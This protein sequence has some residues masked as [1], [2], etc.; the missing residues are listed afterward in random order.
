MRVSAS[1]IAAVNGLSQQP[2]ARFLDEVAS[3]RPAPGGGSSSAVTVALA[4][5][6]VEMAAGISGGDPEREGRARTLRAA[7]LELAERD[8]TSYETVFDALRLPQDDPE[9]PERVEAALEEASRPPA[10]IAEAAAEI[11]ELGAA[12]ANAA[13]PSVRGDALAGCLLAEAAAAAAATLVEINLER[14]SDHPL[15]ERA[16]EARRRAGEARAHD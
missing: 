11:A 4:A 5:A 2:L 9:R 3:T 7:A 14:R 13:G 8:L 1:T 10:E 16:R 6:L 12:V 15:R